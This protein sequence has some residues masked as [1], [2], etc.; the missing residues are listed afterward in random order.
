[1]ARNYYYFIP[2]RPVTKK[3]SMQIYRNTKTGQRFISQSKAYK[4]YADSAAFYLTDRPIRPI[5]Y[6]VQVCCVYY[7]DTRRKVDLANL[8]AATHDILVAAG[9]LADDNRDI[10]ASLDGSRVLY[11]KKRP[12]AEISISP[13]TGYTQWKNDEDAPVKRVRV[14]KKGASR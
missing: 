3:N 1:M 13:L 2:G 6:P 9:I 7:M 5:D 11:D 8:I 4:A 10:V 14:K 12:R